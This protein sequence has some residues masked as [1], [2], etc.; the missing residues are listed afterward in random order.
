MKK[1]LILLLILSNF[2]SAVSSVITACGTIDREQEFTLYFDTNYKSGLVEFRVFKN[3]K[4]ISSESCPIN[5]F[6]IV[7]THDYIL[8]TEKGDFYIPQWKSNKKPL[9]NQ[10]PVELIRAEDV[11]ARA[12]GKSRCSII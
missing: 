5:G 12:Y 4:C 6:E 11:Y 2:L 10:Q 7:D 8:K 3:K 9:F 1:I